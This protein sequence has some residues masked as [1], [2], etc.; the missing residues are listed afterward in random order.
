S[1]SSDIAYWIWDYGDPLSGINVDTTTES[2]QVVHIYNAMGTYSPQLLIIDDN[3]CS[4]AISHDI[5]IWPIPLTAFTIV[6]TVQQGNI[7]LQNLSQNAIEY[8]WDFDYDNGE[9]SA[10]E[11]P[12][13]QYEVDGNYDI[14]LVSY[15]DYG[16]PDTVHQM[17]NLLF[18][19]LFLPN[20]FIPSNSNVELREFKP[21]GINLKSYRLEVYSAWGNLV[22]EST[23]LV[24]GVPAD[25]WDGTYENKEMP[26]GSYIW[27]VS[28]V[29]EDGTIW[30]GTDNGDGNTATSGSVTLIR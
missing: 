10:E 17:Y 8:Y 16:C 6:D 30:K 7:Y 3:N 28:A 1:D 26:T 13:H 23:R 12:T 27:R 15:N 18:T 11:N 21:L 25:G 29:F 2:I 22:F 14:M 4:D 19:N 24:D 9:S 20:A 5:E